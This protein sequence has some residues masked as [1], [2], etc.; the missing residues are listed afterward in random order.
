MLLGRWVACVL[1]LYTDTVTATISVTVSH[2]NSN[3]YYTNNISK[4]YAP[5]DKYSYI[6]HVRMVR[7]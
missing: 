1:P 3:F 7:T 6:D 4:V 5:S 2:T